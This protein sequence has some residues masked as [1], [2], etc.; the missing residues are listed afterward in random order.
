MVTAGRNL[1]LHEIGQATL[2]LG[3][4]HK[5]GFQIH[6]HGFQ[7]HK[8]DTHLNVTQDMQADNSGIKLYSNNT[9][10]EKGTNIT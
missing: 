2:K 5:H 4:R 3:R 8:L 10:A 7:I 1:N 9:R 6:K